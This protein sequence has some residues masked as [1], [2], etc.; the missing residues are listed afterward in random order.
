MDLPAI[1]PQA[2]CAGLLT[3]YLS[4]RHYNGG[5]PMSDRR[6][7]AEDLDPTV[8]EAH[9]QGWCRRGGL[10]GRHQNSTAPA[11]TPARKMPLLAA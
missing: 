5:G 11:V 7:L 8:A 3:H 10:A 2:R 9:P 4:A 1:P 6:D